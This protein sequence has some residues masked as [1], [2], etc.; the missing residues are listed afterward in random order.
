MSKKTVNRIL[1]K[2][3]GESLMGNEKYGISIDTVNIIASYLKNLLNKKTQLCI[4]IGGGNIF[5]G[6]EASSLGMERANADYMGMLATVLNGLALQNA[7]EKI[8]IETRV[9]SALP[10]QSICET[11]IRRRAIRHMEKNRIV[12]CTAGTGNPYF[13]T[14][15]SAALRAAELDCDVIYKATQVD[16]IYNKDPKKFKNA[17]RYDKITY[18]KYL[19]ENLKVMDTSAITIA[20]DNKIS[21]KLFS[22]LEKNCFLKM[23]MNKI[24]NS[25]I[26]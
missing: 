19:T 21:I 8:N 9:M 15:T 22:I 17:K 11:Y 18:Q 20:R 6:L 1:I 2:L 7:L 24:K 10:I 16:G 3:S 12:I 25:E 4:V 26:S 14:D 5:R 23:Y 13:S